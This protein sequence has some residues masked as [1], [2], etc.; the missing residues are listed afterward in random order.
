MKIYVVGLGPGGAE[1]ITPKA[2]DV[3]KKCHVIVGYTVYIDLIK[4][5][6]PGTIFLTTPMRREEERCRLAIEKAL[7]GYTV[8]MVS[9]GDAGV[10]GMAGIMHEIAQEYQ[11]VEVEVIP[12]ITAACSG[13]ALLGSPLGHDFAVISLSD[14]LTPWEKIE[15]RLELAAQADFVIC[16][17]NPASKK[18]SDYLA[19]ASE[20]IMRYQRGDLPVGI[21]RNIGREGETSELTTLAGLKE[22]RVDMF[23]TVII[24]NS[25]T[26]IINQK[27][28][29]PRGYQTND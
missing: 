4:D 16:I 27:M 28:I 22:L 25:Q 19:R 10:Y 1:H 6:F 26:K 3:L 20:I 11:G 9:S 13:G 23:T 21:V 8:A 7:E 14:L 24:G 5:D 15:T 12:G 18:R 29:T 17:Y 2:V